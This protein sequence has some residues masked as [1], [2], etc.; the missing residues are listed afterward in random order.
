[1]RKIIIPSPARQRVVCKS[2]HVKFR[3]RVVI[4][5]NPLPQFITMVPYLY[6]VFKEGFEQEI[7]G[8]TSITMTLDLYSHVLPDIKKDAIN[9]LKGLFSSVT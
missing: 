2:F 7:L 6:A 4:R 5:L 3:Y 9:K 1:M 8:H